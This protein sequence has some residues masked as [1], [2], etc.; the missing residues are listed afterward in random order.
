MS[1]ITA[2]ASAWMPPPP[3]PW[4]ARAAISCPMDCDAP[5]RNDPM[6]NVNIVAWKTVR[7]P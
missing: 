1:P 5:H 7:R 6:R 4:K 3:R 2:K